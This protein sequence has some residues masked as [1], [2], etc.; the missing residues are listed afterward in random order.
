MTQRTLSDLCTL[1]AQQVD[2]QRSPGDLYI[3]LEHV[4]SG[5]LNREAGGLASDVQSSKYRFETD[6]VLY[7][8]LRPYLDKA[9]LAETGGVC[10]TELL[11]LRPNQSVDARFLA[12]LVHAPQFIEHAVSGTTGAQ[13]PRTSWHHIAEFPVPNFSDAEQSAFADLVWDAHRSLRACEA[14]CETAQ[15]LKRAT[16][17]ELFTR[18]LRGEAQKDSEI[19]PLPES[20]EVLRLGDIALLERG[21]FLHRPRNEPR[22]YGGS[23]PFVQ[24]GDVVRSGGLIVDYSQTLNQDGVATPCAVNGALAHRSAPSPSLST[25]ARENQTFGIS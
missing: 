6:D 18:G 14:A 15:D 8:K 13:H 5:R 10:T 2:P 22:F 24:T 17:R 4:A 11:V 12:A 1:V 25:S 23:T 20:W 9:I 7:G 21:R 16:M 3:G 19:G